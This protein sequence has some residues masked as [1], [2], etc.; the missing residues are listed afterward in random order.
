MILEVKKWPESQDVMHNDG[1]FFIMAG[2]GEKDPLG[3]SAYARIID[4]KN[5][6]GDASPI[7]I[8]PDERSDRGGGI[9]EGLHKTWEG[10]MKYDYECEH[11]KK[12]STIVW[13]A[14]A[15]WDIKNQRHELYSSYDY[16]ECMKCDS[17]DIIEIR[18]PESESEEPKI[19][20]KEKNNG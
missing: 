19:Q 13:D 3:N 16:A 9:S 5:N 14:H 2:N 18:I 6:K 1:W 12:D 10:R 11:C 15:T 20:L 8:L 7:P 4:N 17:T